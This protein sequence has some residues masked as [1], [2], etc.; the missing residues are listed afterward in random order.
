M[1]RFVV[2]THDHPLL[3][4]DFML[5]HEERLRTWRLGQP[6][7][8]GGAI[9]AEP[10]P[11]HRLAYLDYEGPVSGDRGHVTRWDRGEY[12]TIDSSPRQIV[13]RLAGERLRGEAVLERSEAAE[14][15]T[16]RFNPHRAEGS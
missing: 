16:F 13:V 14:S 9:V 7:D 2:L 6:P 3:H 10:L 11:D 12:E 8:V 4:W 15:W 1:S 5:E